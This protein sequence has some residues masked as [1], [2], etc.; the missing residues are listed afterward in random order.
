MNLGMETE[1][2]E[3]KKSTGEMR[4]AMESIASILNKHGHGTL[5]NAFAHRNYEDG[6][7][8]QVDVFWDRVDIYSPGLFPEGFTPE[9][10]LIEGEGASKP[11]NRLIAATLYRSGDIEAYGTGLQRIK[12]ACEEAEVPFSVAQSKHGVHVIF[13]RSEALS[14]AGSP[15]SADS[16]QESLWGSCPKRS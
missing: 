5:F 11:R 6:S 15:T 1:C 3:Y 16:S 13:T 8:V 12:G 7:A 10:Y 2:T 14:A 4:E 9:E